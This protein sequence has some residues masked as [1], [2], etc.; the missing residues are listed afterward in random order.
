MSFSEETIAI[1][2][3]DTIVKSPVTETRDLAQKKEIKNQFKEFNFTNERET[4]RIE[5]KPYKKIS[6][7]YK[8]SPTDFRDISDFDYN[9][10]AN[11]QLE[12]D[13]A[14]YSHTFDLEVDTPRVNELQEIV[15][16]M[17]QD[18][19]ISARVVIMNKGYNANAFVTQDG[20]IFISQ[21]LLNM[22]DTTDEVAAVIAHELN[23]LIHKTSETRHS[24]RDIVESLALGWVHEMAA[25]YQ[26]TQLMEKADYNTWAFTSAIQKI[27]G[28]NRSFVHQTGLTRSVQMTGKHY[29]LDSKTSQ[30]EFI[31]ISKDLQTDRPTVPTNQE[32]LTYYSQ[33]F[34]RYDTDKDEEESIIDTIGQNLGLLYGRDLEIVGKLIKNRHKEEHFLKEDLITEITDRLH[35]NGASSEQTLLFSIAMRRHDAFSRTYEEFSYN[36]KSPKEFQE[37][38]KHADEYEKSMTT[39]SLYQAIF[40]TQAKPT[41]RTPDIFTQI[42][43]Y[44][45]DSSLY[46][47]DFGRKEPFGVPLQ[48]SDIPRTLGFLY[49]NIA[50]SFANE[51]DYRNYYEFNED[52]YD[53]I[54]HAHFYLQE[55]FIDMALVAFAHRQELK[56]SRFDVEQMREYFRSGKEAGILLHYNTRSN[57]PFWFQNA[58][59]NP[60]IKE[61][62]KILAELYGISLTP[63]QKRSV[64]ADEIVEEKLINGFGN[65][66]SEEY[67]RPGYYQKLLEELRSKLHMASEE[68]RNRIVDKVLHS[69]DAI[70]F[71]TQ[72]DPLR[73]LNGEPRKS[74][75]SESPK[76]E[77]PDDQLRQSIVKYMYKLTTLRAL[78]YDDSSVVQKIHDL[79]EQSQIDTSEL[80]LLQLINL[81]SNIIRFKNGNSSSPAPIAR[82]FGSLSLISGHYS[83]TSKSSNDM[84]DL[85]FIKDLDEKLSTLELPDTM[86]EFLEF[87][88]RFIDKARMP[89]KTLYDFLFSDSFN[90]ILIAKPFREKFVALLASELENTVDFSILPLLDAFPGS[91]QKKRIIKDYHKK[92]LRRESASSEELKE[93]VDYLKLHFDVLGPEGMSY[94]AEQIHTITEYR[95]F[96]QEMGE[97]INSYLEGVQGDALALP[98]IDFL[99]SYGGNKFGE[100]F[101]T[102]QNSPDAKKKQT[103]KAAEKW[104]DQYIKPSARPAYFDPHE[105]KVV[106]AEIGRDKFK[107]F[108]D[109]VEILH[110]LT[111]SQR[112]IATMKLLT[113]RFGALTSSENRDELAELACSAIGLDN[114]FIADVL[115]MTVTQADQKLVGLLATRMLGPILFRAL[116]TSQTDYDQVLLSH[117][118]AH[119][120]ITDRSKL[121]HI[122]SSPTRDIVSFGH[123]YRGAGNERLQEEARRSGELYDEAVE[124]LQSVIEIEQKVPEYDEVIEIDPGV[125]AVISGIEGSSPIGVRSLQLARQLYTFSPNV[126][127]RLSHSLDRNPGLEKIFVWENLLKWMDE[128]ESL[129]TFMET[130]VD[131]IDDYLGGGSLYTTL[132]IK[133]KSEV[134]SS[135]DG[136]IKILN[137][138][139]KS[140]IAMNYVSSQEVLAKMREQYGSKYSKEIDM[141][142][143]LIDLSNAW[144]L[145]DIGDPNFAI[146]DPHFAKVLADYKTTGSFTFSQ[147]EHLKD[148]GKVKVEVRAPGRTINQVLEDA[149]VDIIKKQE[150]VRELGNFMLHQLQ[151]PTFT[152]EHGENYL[153]IHSDPHTGNYIFDEN[154]D[155]QQITVIDRSMYLRLSQKDTQ[156]MIS[157]IHESD[158]TKF[159]NGLIDRILDANKEKAGNDFRRLGIKAKILAAVGKEKLAQKKGET[160]E[161]NFHLL[162]TALS[163]LPDGITPPLS[164]LLMIKN[165]AGMGEL[166]NQYELSW[167]L[168]TAK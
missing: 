34:Q 80:S 158:G 137:P 117:Q 143:M 43:R 103:T 28:N 168:L 37:L 61:V 157:L 92:Q 12:S 39:Y 123:N 74:F 13:F 100:I 8:Q 112:Y 2:P 1:I 110:D 20:T 90:S 48:I 42:Q 125:E 5:L 159:L 105:G 58:Q 55:K 126:E 114:G 82:D 26:T 134:G 40:E 16:K 4:P 167:D 163:N 116:D 88:K 33:F 3:P 31:P 15:N 140:I 69:L 41:F 44:M 75:S 91:P 111:P 60:S 152:N 108:G 120:L 94:L 135:V 98:F 11:A 56:G 148:F 85:P 68:E 118:Q 63:E 89:S 136:V 19:E 153:V 76:D 165:I 162:Q 78:Y 65:E 146:D 6:V 25:D 115:K 107:S 59:E 71:Q 145:A 45:E 129:R 84:L 104:V 109:L 101:T 70:H 161:S 36:W 86:N 73:A 93:K 72:D 141:L 144:C 128:D 87:S 51:N 139:A 53:D 22:L 99:T 17:L 14:Y 154:S 95:F 149:S 166:L 127:K 10:Y 29:I 96:H 124:L 121:E 32:L 18:T 52:Y 38:L 21:S 142:A 47:S 132:G 35:E 30:N 64:T 113:D 102:A 160:Q 27:S 24:A 49:A 7:K 122:L 119:N 67:M 138:N 79:M 133:L 131:S 106:V 23:H 83:F 97:H 77:Y 164:L 57:I 66:N 156:V 46:I 54:T 151:G 150:L 147:S 155:E 50:K 9:E 81:T 62:Y 130:Q